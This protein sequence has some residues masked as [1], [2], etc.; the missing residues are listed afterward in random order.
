MEKMAYVAIDKD[1]R[2]YGICSADPDYMTAKNG[3][4]DDLKTWR[5]QGAK[6]ELHPAKKAKAMFC[7]NV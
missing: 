3:G 6:I 1:G 2:C 5:K 7:T 4:S